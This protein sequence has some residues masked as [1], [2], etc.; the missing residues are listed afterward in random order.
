MDYK[1]NNRFF[2][3]NFSKK[4]ILIAVCGGVIALLCLFIWWYIYYSNLFLLAAAIGI[5]MVIGAVSIRPKAKDITDQ[6]EDTNKQFHDASAE[7]LKFPSDFEESSLSFHGFIEGKREKILKSGQKITDSVQFST[8]YLK[9]SQLWIRTMTIS[10]IEDNQLEEIC[11]YPLQGMKIAADE[12]THTLTVQS[13]DGTLSL[14]FEAI[15][16][17]FEEFLVKVERQIKKSS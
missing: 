14:A 10:L 12:A 1:H 3:K 7:K 5:G 17:S 4:L 2:D 13:T 15:D 11:S 16:Y 6:I 9:Y 8:L